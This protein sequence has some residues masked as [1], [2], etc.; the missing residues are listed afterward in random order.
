MQ[1]RAAMG[2]EQHLTEESADLGTVA[3]KIIHWDATLTSLSEL[4]QAC[5]PSASISDPL[6][7][8]SHAAALIPDAALMYR[9]SNT[10]KTL[11]KCP[12]DPRTGGLEKSQ[13]GQWT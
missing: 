6:Q 4:N 8:T 9:T 2:Q 5:L 3:A 10:G 11:E 1:S 7:G 12:R 13:A